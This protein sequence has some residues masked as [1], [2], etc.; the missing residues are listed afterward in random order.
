M[1]LTV[2]DMME[3]QRRLQAQHPEWGGLRP[4]RAKEQLL[5]SLCELGEAAQILKKLGDSRVVSDERIRTEFV[6]ELGDAMMYLWDALLCL[7]VDEA[8]FSRVY[9]EKCERNTKRDYIREH[10]ERYGEAPENTE[11]E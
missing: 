8:E 10:V 5:W 2:S 9:R 4:A 1:S 3:Y 6:E 11:G 7:G